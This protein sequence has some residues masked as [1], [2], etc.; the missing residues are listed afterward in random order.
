MIR[1]LVIATAVMAMFSGVAEASKRVPL[2]TNVNVVRAECPFYSDGGSCAPTPNQVYW[3]PGDDR[4]TLWHE[5]G[6]TYDWQYLSNAERN[7]YKPRLGFK[8]SKAWFGDRAFYESLDLAS[9]TPSE[10]FADMYANCAMGYGIPH[11]RHGIT[12][13]EWESAYGY[14][15][16]ISQ[17]RR[18]C[19]LLWS[20]K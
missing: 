13:V 16:S 20:T 4:W 8:I 17:Q 19:R 12:V 14:S 2:P 3:A 11:K 10:R 6:H 9:A 7:V 15:A 1:R 18:N 5:Y